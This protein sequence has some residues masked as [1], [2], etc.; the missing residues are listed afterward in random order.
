VMARRAG[1]YHAQLLLES[2]ERGPLHRLLDLWLPV[3]AELP[4]ARRVRYA[5]DVDPIDVQ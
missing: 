5:L 1:R 4:Q 3:V 2:R